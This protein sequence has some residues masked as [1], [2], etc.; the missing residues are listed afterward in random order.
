MAAERPAAAEPPAWVRTELGTADLGDGRL[1]QRLLRIV[2]AF[3]AHPDASIPQASGT[4][5]Q[6]KAAYRFLANAKV[7]PEQILKPHQQATT[8]RTK[9]ERVVL[10]V[11][12]TTTLNYT[13]HAATT[14][15]GLIDD[16]P[17]HQGL[18]VHSTV[19]FTPERVP[20][21]LLHQQTWTRSPAEHG[22]TEARRERPTEAKESQK[23]R[24]SLKA[25]EAVQRE[26]PDTQLINIGDREADVYDL[27]LD[28]AQ[29]RCAL[30][31]RAA[32]DRRVEHPERYLW[33]AV[34]AAPPAG[35]LTVHVPR[36]RDRAER[37]AEVTVRF[38]PLTL[39]PPRHRPQLAPVA[40]WAVSLHEPAPPPGTEP[41]EWLLLTTLPVTTFADAVRIAEYYAVR[42][43][44]ELFHKV[45]K[46]GCRIEARQLQA[47]ARLERCLALLSIVAWRVMALTLLGRAVPDLPCTALFEDWEWQALYC[48][49]HQTTEP[50]AAPPS[51]AE[52]VRLVAR[53]GGFLGRRRDGPPGV[54]VLWRG[55]QVLSVIAAA[56]RAFGPPRTVQSRSP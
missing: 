24:N 12:D 28:A 31:V 19:A 37:S 10:A 43:M 16:K 36:T 14:G 30:L 8:D 51:L 47:A 23:W 40:I 7:T 18:L 11:Q 2:A 26:A 55:M 29:G 44:I 27:F 42:F 5:G 48:F 22:K 53:V 25:T 9:P 32:W 50:P 33:A 34:E 20:L 17:D 21:G 56:W 41:L 4:W 52:A 1:T 39:R 46:S 45:L 35:T 15:L 49:V 38:C 13:R 3:G 54:I 6:A